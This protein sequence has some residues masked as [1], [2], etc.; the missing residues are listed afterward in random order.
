MKTFLILTAVFILSNIHAVVV[1]AVTFIVTLIIF[2]IKDVIEDEK[3]NG[4]QG[5]SR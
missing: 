1:A 4:D 2:T 5:K 3:D